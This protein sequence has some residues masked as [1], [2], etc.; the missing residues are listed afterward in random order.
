[1]I[2]MRVVLVKWRLVLIDGSVMFM[3]VLLSMIISML[4]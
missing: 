4:R 1:M 3:I 2:Y